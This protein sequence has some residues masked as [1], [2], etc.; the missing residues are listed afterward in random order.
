MGETL[1]TERL[2]AL[3]AY[4]IMDTAPEAA[5]DRITDLAADI[6]DV[7]I[8]L[9]SLVD[10]Q[11]Q[12]FKA[13]VGLEA[14]STPRSWAFCAHAI[15]QLPGSTLVVEDAT[16]DSRFKDS[17]LVVGE[18]HVRFYAGAVLTSPSGAN[19]GTLCLIDRIPR[20]SPSAGELRRLNALA[21]IVVDE[22]EL[23][24]ATREAEALGR[25]LVLAA[26]Q[27]DAANQAKSTFLATMSH[28]IRTP[29]NGVLGMAQAIAMGD[30]EP[31]Q[32]ER[33]SVIQRS[34]EALMVILNDVLDLSRIEAGKVDL[35]AAEFD[36]E[37]LARG[38][39]DLF[40]PIAEGKDCRFVLTVEA[41]A[42]GV[43]LGDP[44]RVRQ[45]LCNLVSNALK[46]TDA[47]EIRLAIRA[48]EG[49]LALCVQ[50]TGVGMADD[51]IERLFR[52]FEQADA[53]IRRR[54]GGSGLGLAICQELVTMMGGQIGAQ[55]RLGEGST[56][57][58]TLPLARVR[59]RLLPA[60]PVAAEPD[61]GTDLPAPALRVLVAEDNRVNQ[62][63]ILALLQHIAVVPKIVDDGQAAVEAWE[64]GD[65]DLIL[66]DMQM[67]R[68][69]GLT[70]ARIIRE[71]E[72]AAGRA[73][74]PIIA[75]TANAMTDQVAA[76]LDAGMDGFVA[77]PI[78]V[79][80]LFATIER[81]LTPEPPALRR[82]R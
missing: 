2:N 72:R 50:D 57:T 35:Q 68:M 44:T 48:A 32:R 15:Q 54:F 33:L 71:R 73:R 5:F 66:M 27:A 6:F 67:P 76:Y 8:A 31:A 18:P 13:K 12:W 37:A 69:D 4:E 43:Y 55:S 24:R 14:D 39:A 42:A 36:I 9:V 60:P 20:P 58:V 28:E 64:A 70:A 38:V 49:E 51:Q 10:D 81:A 26:V 40:A 80:Q 3:M 59:D 16:R 34:G 41:P 47:G 11:R 29:L 78:E 63:V 46:F 19:L 61:G 82:V 7:P 65:W 22:L 62:L 17:P 45:I 53:S 30:L 25:S 77:K 74:T 52:K 1:E 75:L 23:R 56:F 79:G 21:A